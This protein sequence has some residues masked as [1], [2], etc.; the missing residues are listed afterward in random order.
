MCAEANDPSVI[1]ESR[2]VHSPNAGEAAV[3]PLEPLRSVH[4]TSFPQILQRH[5]F[6]LLVTTYQA[7]QLVILRGRRRRAEHAFPRLQHPMGLAVQGDRLAI[8]TAMEI[9]EFHNMPAVAAK[10]RTCRQARRLLFAAS[11]HA[12]ATSRFTKW[13]GWTTICGSS[14]PVSPACAPAVTLQ[15]RARVGGRRSSAT[16]PRGPLP[17]Q[18]PGHG[19]RQTALRHGPGRDR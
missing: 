15:F 7:G 5:G 17:P 19:R 8:G 6:S 12:R 11:C 18:R 1:D 13:P 3:K 9:W 2:T 16:C 4:T 10:A 14:T